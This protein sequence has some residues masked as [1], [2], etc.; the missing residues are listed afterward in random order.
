MPENPNPSERFAYLTAG[1]FEP[2][3]LAMF[4]DFYAFW[5]E[6]VAKASQEIVEITS[7]RLQKEIA[8][9]AKLAGCRDAKE[10]AEC[11]Q[12]LVDEFSAQVKEDAPRVSRTIASVW[13]SS[14]VSRKAA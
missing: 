8:L 10:F 3:Y 6:N 11:Q 2:R 7:S 5:F 13:A 14:E 4:G 12:K 9:W 1:F